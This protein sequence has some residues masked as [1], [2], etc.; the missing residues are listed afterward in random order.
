MAHALTEGV[1][2]EF[3]IDSETIFSIRDDEL[4]IP[5]SLVETLQISQE[6]LKALFKTAARLLAQTDPDYGMRAYAVQDSSYKWRV[7]LLPCAP[8]DEYDQTGGTCWSP[9]AYP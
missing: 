3:G 9:E 5:R 1:D 4:P 6:E 8:F 7:G 2:L